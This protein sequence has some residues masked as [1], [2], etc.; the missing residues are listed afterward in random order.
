M[1]EAH[2]RTGLE[3]LTRL[4]LGAAAAD[5]VESPGVPERVEVFTVDDVV[6]V[7]QDAGGAAL[8]AVELVVAV[9]G[10][11]GVEEP[12]DDVVSA[13]GLPA[14]EDH[15]HVA[16]LPDGG[17]RSLGKGDAALAVGIGKEG[18]DGILVALGGGLFTIDCCYGRDIFAE[19]L[20]EFGLIAVAKFL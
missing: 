1:G 7:L 19:N 18:L 8:E 13:G 15:A 14:A 12:A 4:Q 10:L 17:V 2:S 6:G 20:W 16:L 3:L 9:G 11:Q 5:D